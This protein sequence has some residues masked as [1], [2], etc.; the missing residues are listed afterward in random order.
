LKVSLDLVF[1]RS[2]GRNHHENKYKNFLYL[3]FPQYNCLFDSLLN[4][5][6]EI[7]LLPGTAYH[8]FTNGELN[9]NLTPFIGNYVDT[10]NK[11]PIE[12]YRQYQGNHHYLLD[13]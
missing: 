1:C 4:D 2:S 10:M 3:K 7:N 8:A 6:S 12:Y 5:N 13:M 9:G 11:Q